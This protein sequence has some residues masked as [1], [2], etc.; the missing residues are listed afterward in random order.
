M[1]F[2]VVMNHVFVKLSVPSFGISPARTVMGTNGSTIA[3]SKNRRDIVS[4]FCGAK[5]SALVWAIGTFCGSR[6][7]GDHTRFRSSVSEACRVKVRPALCHGA[8]AVGPDLPR[9]SPEN[10]PG[11]VYPFAAPGG[12]AF[13]SW[14]APQGWGRTGLGRPAGRSGGR[15]PGALCRP[16]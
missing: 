16:N 5:T 2:E 15:P 9:A 1:V 3:G 4:S 7:D 14:L 11:A 13:P 10:E 6:C 12:P 8:Q